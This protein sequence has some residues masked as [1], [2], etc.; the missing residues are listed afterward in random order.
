MGSRPP[1]EHEL[2]E[3][4]CAA[5]LL[6]V[7]QLDPLTLKGFDH[8]YNLEYP[9]SIA[10]F[11]KAVQ[12]MPKDPQRHTHL[13]QAVVFS[14]MERAGALESEMVT[15]ANSFF[16]RP[17][18]EPSADEDALFHKE[19]SEALQLSAA[20]LKVRNDDPQALYAQGAALA[21]RGTWRFLVRKE[22]MDALRDLTSARKAHNKVAE[23][24][25]ENI[26][27]RMMQGAH[28]YVVGSLPFGYR[29]LGFLAGF[30]GDQAKGLHPLLPVLV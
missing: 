1:G 28:D 3:M 8:F 15:G 20:A 14:V 17:K 10:A 9:E 7:S 13:A 18:M 2:T 23:L 6:L 21:L 25:P 27:A 30:N 29:I 24:Q 11:R 16:R 26:D 5:V 4:F 12:A 19:I 22:W